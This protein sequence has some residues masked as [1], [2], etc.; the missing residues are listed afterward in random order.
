MSVKKLWQQVLAQVEL[1]I[2]SANFA[3]WFKNTK[4]ASQEQGKIIVSTP[5]SF[6][7]EW[8]EKKYEPELLKIVRSL[9]PEVN[10]I[11]FIVS[12]ESFP[13][14]RQRSAEKEEPGQEQLKVF[15]TDKQTGLNPSYTFENFVVGGFNELAHAAASAVAEQ[16]GQLYNPLFLYG[17]VGLGK[18]HLLEAIG[19]Q[20]IRRYSDRKVRYVPS[21]HLV[22]DII[23]SIRNGTIA[24]LKSE[25]RTID[26]LII[27]DVQFLAGKEKTQEEFFHI[28]NTLYQKAKQIIL[29]SDRPP[30]AI[31]SLTKR[32]RSRFEGGMIADIGLPD[33]ETRIAILKT[34]AHEKNSELSDEL[35]TF[36]ATNIK[37][38]VRE[39][40]G[41]LNRII[42]FEKVKNKKIDTE[43]ARKLVED[44]T[45]GPQQKLTSDKIIKAVAEFYDIQKEWLFSHSR[46]KEIVKP[47]HIAMYLMRS[48]L[49]ASYPAIAKK[50][51][52]KDHTT[53]IYS[54]KKIE[55]ALDIDKELG[56]DI[57]IIQM[58]MM[59]V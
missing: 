55:K 13:K 14:R 4:I 16:P 42:L 2:S 8:L 41:A 3:T 40:E 32:L 29:S 22:S 27:D 50:F 48:K 18:T 33:F 39:L 49:E 37:T 44:F 20:I 5:N 35:N 31:P 15:Q 12:K 10:Q 11:E 59:N 56:Q 54:C 30:R 38:N 43:R 47:R 7:K 36:L 28:F 46:K 53:A 21:E 17:Q 24:E 34:K 45:T 23:T 9:D 26:V 51:G 52:G 1:D 57:K 19:N 58:R 6:V 25:Y